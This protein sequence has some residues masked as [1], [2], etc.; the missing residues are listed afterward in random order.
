[1]ADQAIQNAEQAVQARQIAEL[2]ENIDEVAENVHRMMALLQANIAPNANAPQQDN[3]DDDDE[4]QEPQARQP[5]QVV[6]AEVPALLHV[7]QLLDYSN[8]R[9]VTIFDKAA[10]SLSTKFDMKQEHLFTFEKELRVRAN[11]M[12]WSE[13]DQ[14]ITWHLNADGDRID[15]ISPY[16]RIDAATLRISSNAFV[17]PTGV[18]GHARANQNNAQ[19]WRC[20]QETLTPLAL[21]RETP[22]VA[23][24]RS[25]RREQ[26]IPHPHF[27]TKP[28]CD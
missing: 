3:E 1:M 21:A 12:G 22:S 14:N 25:K 17:L 5:H 16:G 2:R 9:D 19:M 15:L 26:L 4:Q 7:G 6:Y 13:G 27:F 11:T 28:L 23:N 8:K 20:I 24:T 18:L 10:A